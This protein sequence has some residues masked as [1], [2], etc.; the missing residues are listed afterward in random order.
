MTTEIDPNDSEVHAD[1]RIRT[2]RVS[3]AVGL[4]T[5]ASPDWYKL[6]TVDYVLQYVCTLSWV[7][8]FLFMSLACWI[9]WFAVVTWLIVQLPQLYHSYK[10]SRQ[11][12][13]ELL[14]LE[15]D[16]LAFR[17]LTVLFIL[18]A[19]QIHWYRD[20]RSEERGSHPKLW[21]RKL[22]VWDYLSRYFPI[23]L[24]LADEIRLQKS[25]LPRKQQQ[26]Q[27]PEANNG[28]V[29]EEVIC[30]PALFPADQNYLVGY[31]PHGILGFGAFTNFATEATGFSKKFPGLTPWLTTLEM[32]F[33][34]PFHRDM[35][36]SFNIVVA[37]YKGITYLLDPNQCGKRGNM[38]IV[39]L[40]GAP[41][42]LDSRPGKYVFHTNRRYGFFKLALMTGVFAG[43]I[44]AQLRPCIDHYKLD[45]VLIYFRHNEW[46]LGNPKIFLLRANTQTG[47]CKLK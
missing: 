11:T 18:V 29:S 14:R 3:E 12:E 36:Q 44:L 2:R 42:A 37:T 39:V 27:Q 33:K 45:I 13:P 30:N 4:R 43:H 6:L 5:K 7:C 31:H 35:L 34:A 47:M 32:N 17:Y 15:F 23:S 22:A 41:E 8:F 28:K 46:K 16:R 38:V 24:I 19:Y 25:N 21:V 1:I 26:Q 9:F 10:A 40:G 20:R